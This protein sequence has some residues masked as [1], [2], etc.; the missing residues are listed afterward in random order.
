MRLSQPQQPRQRD[1]RSSSGSH[2]HFNS[3]F[4]EDGNHKNIQ[5]GPFPQVRD[6][7]IKAR[8]L[9]F[10]Q[11]AFQPEREE[12]ENF[13]EWKDD[14]EHKQDGKKKILPPLHQNDQTIIDG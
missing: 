5:H 13:Y 4:L 2:F 3:A 1:P 8:Q 9:L 7:T 12:R 6:K 11:A 10:T 14:R